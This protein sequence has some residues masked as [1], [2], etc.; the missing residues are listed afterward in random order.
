MASKTII[1]NS[2][3]SISYN[4]VTITPAPTPS[5]A[6]ETIYVN[7]SGTGYISQAVSST[8]KNRIINGDMVIAQRGTAAVTSSNAT[9]AYAVDRWVMYNGTAITL[10]AQQSA[11][12]PSGF[13]NSLQFS[14][15]SA[16]NSTASQNIYVI[17][18]VEG[19]NV[20][21]LNYG[22]VNAKTLTASFWVKSSVTGT[23]SGAAALYPVAGSSVTSYVFTYTISQT[24]TWEKKTVQIPGNQTYA[25]PNVTNGVGI[26]FSFDLGSGTNSE[27]SSGTWVIGDYNRTSSTV[28]WANN[29]NATFKITGVQL[30]AGSVATPFEYRPQQLE[31]SLCRRYYYRLTSTGYSNYT[32]FG[33]GMWTTTT[34]F[35][36]Y[37]KFPTPMRATPTVALTAATGFVVYDTAS[38]TVSLISYYSIG[39]DGVLMTATTATATAGKAGVIQSNNSNSPLIEFTSEL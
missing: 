28:K 25:I 35:R 30:E 27:S 6:G 39:Y 21:D 34:N 13:S 15:T 36:F 26:Y 8:F 17:Q 4:D 19:Y 32:T 2:S 1:N 16:M 29:A 31:L 3:G 12:A 7:S 24:N 22:T 14:T 20:S 18:R 5:G 33:R 9:A 37:L 38:R 10:T 23:Y 11:D